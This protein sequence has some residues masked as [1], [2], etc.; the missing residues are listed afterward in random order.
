VLPVGGDDLH[1][2]QRVEWV[3]P[4][5]RCLRSAMRGGSIEEVLRPEMSQ[6]RSVPILALV[7]GPAGGRVVDLQSK[8]VLRLGELVNRSGPQPVDT[9][10]A[11][12]CATAAVARGVGA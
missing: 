4:E 1:G 3:K 5:V 9:D 11:D 6:Y 2:R 7:L 8:R 10:Q 12:L